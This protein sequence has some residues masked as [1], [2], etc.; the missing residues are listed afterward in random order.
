L[1]THQVREVHVVY[2][3]RERPLRGLPNPLPLDELV[4]GDGGWEVELGFGK[5]RYLLE[6]AARSPQRRFLGIERAGK[7]FRLA[8][9]RARA[10]GLENLLLLEGEALYLLATALPAAFASTL[11]IYFPDPWPKS[12]HHRRRLLDPSSIDLALRALTPG[13]RLFFATDFL[14]YGRRVLDALTSHGGLD[15]RVLE[16]EWPDGARTN[17]EAKYVE[18]GREILRLEATASGE[19][20]GLHPAGAAAVL[21]ATAPPPAADGQEEQG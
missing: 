16:G 14:S 5:G 13:G 10:R 1:G 17:Y 12:R 19:G 9:R 11:H 2:G 18:E 15:V 4:P 3:D 7:Y 6:Q 20:V 8:R 21:A